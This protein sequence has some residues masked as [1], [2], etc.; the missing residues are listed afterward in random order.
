MRVFTLRT[1]ELTAESFSIGDLI[2]VCEAIDISPDDLTQLLR[3]THAGTRRLRALAAVAW[4]MARHG[5]PELTLD[6]VL[7]GRIEVIGEV[8]DATL[9]PTAPRSAARPVVSGRSS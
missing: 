6:Q 8:A 9:D 5:E 4:V 3:D 1:G 2:D 7:A